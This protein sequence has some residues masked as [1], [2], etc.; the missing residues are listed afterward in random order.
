MIVKEL[1]DWLQDKPDESILVYGVPGSG[2][3]EHEELSSEKIGVLS[4]MRRIDNICN[5]A[6]RSK[7]KNDDPGKNCEY[8]PCQFYDSKMELHCSYSTDNSKCVIT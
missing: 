8:R 7:I 4:S 3:D 2:L 1:R 5:Q 6:V